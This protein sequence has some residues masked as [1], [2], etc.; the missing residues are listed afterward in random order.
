MGNSSLPFCH[1]TAIR[2]AYG[3]MADIVAVIVPVIE[4]LPDGKLKL[5]VTELPFVAALAVKLNVAELI[6]IKVAPFVYNRGRL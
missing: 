3:P 4:L 2:D 5:P 1:K 6:L